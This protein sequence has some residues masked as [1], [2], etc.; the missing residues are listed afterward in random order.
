MLYTHKWSAKI[1]KSIEYVARTS[2]LLPR[3]RDAWYNEEKMGVRRQKKTYVVCVCVCVS[4]IYSK[5]W[6]EYHCMQ[7]Y[8]SHLCVCVLFI[9]RVPDLKA[10]W[11]QNTHNT[12]QWILRRTSASSEVNFYVR[13]CEYIYIYI[14]ITAHRSRT[15]Y[16]EPIKG[17]YSF[18]C[19]SGLH[20]ESSPAWEARNNE[21]F[22][23]RRTKKN[24]P[25]PI[26]EYRICFFCIKFIWCS[27]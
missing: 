11:S 4:N 27:K 23:Q 7:H 15:M 9:L 13:L 3:A 16:I 21:T 1:V 14:Y 2:N 25:P 5:T 22:F 17:T 20:L 10:A 24:S 26:R 6:D 12:S 19:V 18:L 8:T